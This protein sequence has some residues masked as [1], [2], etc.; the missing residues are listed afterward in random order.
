MYK[1]L[2]LIVLCS[3]I[4]LITLAGTASA[5]PVSDNLVLNVTFTASGAQ[6]TGPGTY[7][8]TNTGVTAYQLSSGIYAGYFSG[9]D[10]LSIPDADALSF[11]NNIF[12]IEFWAQFNDTTKKNG[13]LTK[14]GTGY[15]YS[16]RDTVLNSNGILN[17]NS[18]TA[19]GTDVYKNLYHTYL[20]SSWNHFIITSDGANSTI[21]KNG[22]KIMNSTKSASSMENTANALRIGMSNEAATY[23]NNGSVLLVR[24]YSAYFTYD[25]V[26]QNYQDQIGSVPKKNGYGLALS[27]DDDFI[28]SWYSYDGFET[29]G[30]NVTFF[31]T[32]TQNT[33]WGANETVIGYLQAMQASGHEIGS[34]TYDH[35]NIPTY[36]GSNTW[37]DLYTT[38]TWPI[39]N[40]LWS[41][42]IYASGFSYPFGSRTAATDEVM[43]TYYDYVRG[44][45]STTGDNGYFL[46]NKVFYY[47]PGSG[48]LI[49]SASIGNDYP[50]VTVEKLQLAID[51]AMLEGQVFCPFSHEI[52][53]AD[54]TSNYNLQSDILDGLLS[55]AD[56]K[57]V[58]FYRMEELVTPQSNEAVGFDP[59]TVSATG[60]TDVTLNVTRTSEFNRTYYYNWA[61]VD[62]TATAGNDY[63]ATN[64]HILL[65]PNNNTASF[66]VH[67]LEGGAGNFSVSLVNPVNS[68]SVKNAAVKVYTANVRPYLASILNDTL[69]DT[70]VAGSTYAVNFTFAN[71]GMNEW[72]RTWTY[73]YGPKDSGKFGYSKYAMIGSAGYTDTVTFLFNITA[74]ATPGTYK[75]R[76]TMRLWNTYNF[77]VDIVKTIV[78]T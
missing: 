10:Y 26:L 44:T 28:N 56:S 63:T 32:A 3:I 38:D 8:I 1:K 61:T 12:T 14:S 7:T 47:T 2:L 70:M 46:P 68:V 74:P 58:P 34:H 27:F 19:S 18:W 73:L 39:L 50:G 22:V 62:G 60:G 42:D 40:L 77:G 57:N 76:Y 53:G 78:V 20:S 9:D 71:A 17:F 43:L 33:N 52:V 66:A 54:N 25:N 72:N 24:M 55:Y 41:N 64:G 6:D 21:Y 5:A 59:A 23:L 69:P 45:A 49:Y 4:G 16:I 75:V 67:L 37:T 36:L 15:E 51:N 35:V 13:V 65:Y 48:K 31:T 29:Y 30:A 11:T